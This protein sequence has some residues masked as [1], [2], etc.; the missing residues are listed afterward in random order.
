MTGGD[1]LSKQQK[2][3]LAGKEL[4]KDIEQRPEDVLEDAKKKESKVCTI[5]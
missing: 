1:G 3:V 5:F 2:G 4:M